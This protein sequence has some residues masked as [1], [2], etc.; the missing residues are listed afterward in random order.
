M[1]VFISEMLE[2]VDLTC[3]SSAYALPKVSMI[4]HARVP[5]L[6]SRA[7]CVASINRT[8]SEVRVHCVRTL[9]SPL[10]GAHNHM[11]IAPVRTNL[12]R[13]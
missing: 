8:T 5:R 10:L 4:T 2:L 6:P 3:R 12:L 11:Q 1:F 13:T 9:E 7:S